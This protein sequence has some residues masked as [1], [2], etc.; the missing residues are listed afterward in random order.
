MTIKKEKE[1]NELP[2][3]YKGKDRV[4]RAVPILFLTHV[5]E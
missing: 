5:M 1:D 3:T 4:E 2:K